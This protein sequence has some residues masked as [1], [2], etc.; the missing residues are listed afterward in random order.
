[1]AWLSTELREP[2]RETARALIAEKAAWLRKY[3]PAANIAEDLLGHQL[4]TL[5]V[6]LSEAVDR[7]Q[8][9]NTHRLLKEVDRVF[10][11]LVVTRL[12][13]RPL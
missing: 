3:E 6:E 2:E 13:R 1:M 5:L 4:R 11:K 10:Y 9:R 12:R 7:L 8:R